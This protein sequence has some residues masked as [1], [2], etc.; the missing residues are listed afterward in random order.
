MPSWN[1]VL[2]ELSHDGVRRK[3]LRKLHA[4]TGR[5]VIAYYSGWLQKEGSDKS[6]I[7]D[8]DKN[9]FMNSVFGLDKSLGLDLILHT[10]GGDVA[11]TESIVFYLR[12]MFGDNIR[13]VVP[14]IA[15]SAGT[16]IACSGKSILMGKHSNLGP[17][18]PHIGGLPTFGVINE[19]E[20]AKEEVAADPASLQIW[21]LIIGKYHPTFLGACQN[22]IDL[23]SQMVTNWLKDG[24]FAG[25]QDANEKADCIVKALNNHH[26]TKSHARH[27]H[28]DEAKQ[29]GLKIIDL[30]SDSVLQDLVLTVHHAYMHTLSN[31][32]AIKIIE[33][34]NGQAIVENIP[35]R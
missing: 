22:A 34:H 18:D 2:N 27:I 25:D 33:N 10:P 20:R 16:M 21:Q 26:D 12:E 9:G 35:Y 31:S 28:I 8:G 17:I 4:H 7:Y 19:F 6:S 30:E 3:Y 11:A 24:M 5:N 32:P 1:D 15:M 23:S 29:M 14:Q 13:V